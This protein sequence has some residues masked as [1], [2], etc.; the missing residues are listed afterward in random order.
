ME[1]NT[2]ARKF[3]AAFAVHT[4]RLCHAKSTLQSANHL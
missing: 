3:H 1:R 4:A 2:A